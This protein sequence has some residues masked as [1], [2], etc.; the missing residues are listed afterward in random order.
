MSASNALIRLSALYVLHKRTPADMAGA[1]MLLGTCILATMLLR[2]VQLACRVSRAGLYMST[3]EPT[4]AE[5][6][7]PGLSDRFSLFVAVRRCLKDVAIS[8][9]SK[10]QK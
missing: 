3:G 5:T 6:V 8:G 1:T 2:S 9:L 4:D 10:S 7:P